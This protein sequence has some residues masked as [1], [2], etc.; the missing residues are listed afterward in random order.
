MSLVQKHGGGV[1]IVSFIVALMLTI[2]P[3]PDWGEI[4]R[5]EWTALV[6]L[7]WCLALP[8]RV[9]VGFGWTIGL[10]LDVIKGSL[11]GQHALAFA[12]IA[13]LTINLHLRIRLYPRWQQSLLIMVLLIL[14]QLLVL[15]FDGIAGAPAKGW[16]YWLPSLTG[17]LMWSPVFAILRTI[18]RDYKVTG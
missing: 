16:S 17:M 5:P 1:I 10:L 11:L 4:L 8:S 14:Y 12:V 15:W 2:L 7:Y 18:W 9:G 3:L 13:Y 6:L